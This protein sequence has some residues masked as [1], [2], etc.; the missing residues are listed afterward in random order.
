MAQGDHQKMSPIE[1]APML[2][3][4]NSAMSAVT[5]F[6]KHTNIIAWL[7]KRLQS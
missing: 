1:Y 5:N 6:L 4:E 7:L 3:Q 2:E